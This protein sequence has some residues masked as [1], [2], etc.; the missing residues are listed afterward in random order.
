[1]I[2]LRYAFLFVL[3]SALGGFLLGFQVGHG[4]LRLELAD[5]NVTEWVEKMVFPT[6]PFSA[7][8]EPVSRDASAGAPAPLSQDRPQP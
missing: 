6:L 4:R 5:K 3:I 7:Q 8:E 2:R 1:M